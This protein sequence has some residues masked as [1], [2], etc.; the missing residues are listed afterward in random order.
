MDASL[1]SHGTH[2]FLAR[3]F[4]LAGNASDTSGLYNVINY[5]DEYAPTVT[6]EAPGEGEHVR[7]TVPIT[8]H[9]VDSVFP[10]GH[11]RSG[12]RSIEVFIDPPAP[13]EFWMLPLA[14]SMT[15]RTGPFPMTL[16]HTEEWNT[17]DLTLGEH[18]IMVRVYDGKWNMTEVRQTVHVARCEVRTGEIRVW[19]T[20][21]WDRGTYFEYTLHVENTSP[22]DGHW[23]TVEERHEGMQPIPDDSDVRVSIE[24][25]GASGDDYGRVAEVYIPI[26]ELPAGAHESFRFRFVPFLTQDD[27]YATPLV[28][29]LARETTLQYCSQPWCPPVRTED[30]SNPVILPPHRSIAGAIDD[31]RYLLVTDVRSLFAQNPGMVGASDDVLVEMARLAVARDG[32]LGYLRGSTAAEF[33]DLIEPGGDW[34]SQLHRRFSQ[35]LEGY[36]LIVGETEVVPSWLVDIPDVSW[37]GG[38]VTTHVPFAD[39]PY[40]DTIGD[41]DVPDLMVGRMIG[42]TAVDLL[43][44]LET[45]VGV[46]ETGSWDR[47]HGLA[48]SGSE[49]T[50]EDFQPSAS[51]VMLAL[52]GQMIPRGG[53]AWALHWT[54]WVHKEEIGTSDGYDFPLDN[55]EGFVLADTDGDG[56]PEMV[57][58]DPDIDICTVFK[59]A[60]LDATL[61]LPWDSFYCQFTPYDGFAAGDIDGDGVDEIIVGIDETDKISVHNDTRSTPGKSWPEF[62]IGFDPWDVLAC[63]DVWGDGR[64]EIIV[65]RTAGGGSVTAYEYD[66]AG[67][68]PVLRRRLELNSVDFASRDGFAVGNLSS[69]HAKDEIVVADESAEEM[70]VY[71]TAATVI[72][73][74]PCDPVTPFDGIAMGDVD[75]DGMDEIAF[76]I[77]DVVDGKKRLFVFQDDGWYWDAADGAWKFHRGGRAA[78]YSRYLQFDGA[79]TTSSTTGHDGF[80]VGDING[81]GDAEV[82]MALGARDRLF[83][84]DGHYSSSW[85]DRYLPQV[86]RLSRDAEIITL[87][88][89]GNPSGCSPFGVAEIGTLDLRANP[90]V[91]SLTCLSGNYE[92]DWSWVVNGSPDNHAGNDEGFAEAFF[93]QGAVAFIGSTHVSSSD[94]NNPA[95]PAFFE[96]WAINEAGGHAFTQYS[97]DRAST[98]NS[99]WEYWVTEYNYYGDPRFGA[100]SSGGAGEEAETPDVAASPPP[101]SVQVQVPTYVVTTTGDYDSVSIPGGEVLLVEGKPVVPFYGERIPIPAGY[102]VQDVALVERSAPVT[103][104]GLNL[105]VTTW[106]TDGASSGIRAPLAL[107]DEGW[108][109]L[110][111]HEWQTVLNADGSSTLVINIYAFDYNGLTQDARFCPSYR[112]QITCAASSVAIAELHTDKGAYAQG[113]PVLIDLTLANAGQAQDLV[114]EVSIRRQGTE[115]WVDGLLLASLP[116]LSGDASFSPGWETTGFAPGRYFVDVAV[117]GAGGELLAHD[118]ALFTL[119]IWAGKV[120][121]LVGAPRH[122]RV[123]DAVD[124]TLEAENSGTVPLSAMAIVRVVDGSGITVATFRRPFSDL[125]PGAT[126]MMVARWETQGAQGGE[127]TLLGYL[128][129]QGM[130]SDVATAAVSTESRIRLPL[131][132]RS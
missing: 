28:H 114:A 90:L 15:E 107:G 73:R 27:K 118:S 117:R 39:L 75:N 108:Y 4:D 99:A 8:V 89:H 105:A 56:T 125:A 20:G 123:G 91:L 66:T 122:F 72:G 46:A 25:G 33:L 59:H 16:D 110:R 92:G 76:I 55:R 85:M 67:A 23:V 97:R 109:P 32:V 112:F 34:A 6:I 126:T 36:L 80:G 87:R 54:K 121:S 42:N 22:A 102:Q 38:K 104:A 47:T 1:L 43:N 26:D 51:N 37:S 74:L 124:L 106:Y 86:A 68:S 88:G 84:Y 12:I 44:A 50:W 120:T 9:A 3:A 40:S 64:D 52:A 69:G 94:Q 62:D 127:Y 57:V 77:D 132:L 21:L 58:A 101:T 17:E 82:V 61:T 35:A 103:Q 45:A 81:D 13:G 96:S 14:A 115:E 95:G 7:C 29:T 128:A 78:I 93:D 10:I 70:V 129:Y 79:R 19:R 83:V 5:P 100:L 116:A 111:D 130:A 11:D 65:A 60:D 113:E 31:S 53:G 63:G 71:N 2:T 30:R 49:G 119:G 18:E 24:R 48:T 98:G 41:D 131:L